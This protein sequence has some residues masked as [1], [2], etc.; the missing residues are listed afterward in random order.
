MSPTK[1]IKIKTWYNELVIDIYLGT[2]SKTEIGLQSKIEF[3][4]FLLI[5]SD[6]CSAS[7]LKI[8]WMACLKIAGSLFSRVSQPKSLTFSPNFSSSSHFQR[9]RARIL[10]AS[11]SNGAGNGVVRFKISPSTDFVIQKGDITHWFI[12]GSSD[13]IVGDTLSPP[14]ILQISI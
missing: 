12:D 5:F 9:S 10:A 1:Y 6:I 3:V 14:F 4:L 11:M 2:P 8:E 7:Y 13:A